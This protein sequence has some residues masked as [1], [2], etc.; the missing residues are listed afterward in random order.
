MRRVHRSLDSD[1]I[2]ELREQLNSE[3]PPS[4]LAIGDVIRH[5]RLITKKSQSEYAKLCGVAPR[6]LADVESGTGNPRLSTLQALLRPFACDVG[7]VRL[8]DE[9]LRKRRSSVQ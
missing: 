3:I 9:E 1:R 7:V 4:D 8:S 2:S 6:A 5:M